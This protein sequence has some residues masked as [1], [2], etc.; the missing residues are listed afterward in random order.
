MREYVSRFWNNRFLEVLNNVRGHRDMHDLKELFI[1]L[2]FLKYANDK[3]SENEDSSIK[4]PREAQWNYLYKIISASNFLD[5]LQI[6]FSS[7]EY[8]NYQVENTFSVF[9]FNNKFKTKED[10]ELIKS[11]FYGITDFG[12]IK[13]SIDFSIIIES[14]IIDFANNEGKKGNDFTTPL[15]VSQLMIELLNPAR[16]SI[17]DSACG[18]GG[19]F[20]KVTD[21]Y[22]KGEFQFYGQEQNQSTLAL[23]KLRFAFNQDD[24]IQFSEAKSTLTEDQF[25]NL[26]VDYIVMHPPFS[27]RNWLTDQIQYDPRFEYGLPPK[28]NA[29]FAW[30]QHALFH[31]NENGKSAVLLNNSS[32]A[33]GG[34]EAEIR[35][36]IIE[37]DLIESIISLPSQLFSNTSIPASIWLLNKNKSNKGEVLFID[38]SS[39]GK[40]INRSQRLLVDKDILEISKLFNSWQEN[41]LRYSEKIGFNKSVDISEIR[42]TDYLLTPVRYV[43]IAELD[44]IDLSKAVNLGDILEYARPTRLDPDVSYKRLSIKDLASNQDS[45]FLDSSILEKGDFRLD[46]RLLEDDILLISRLGNKLKPTYHK[47]SSDKIAFSS[48]VIF[49]FKVDFKQIDIDYLIAELHK[50]YVQFQ[51]DNYRKGTGMSTI[52]RQDLLNVQIFVPPLNE[53]KE[54]FEKEREVRFQSVAKDLGFEKEIAKLKEA[55]MKDLGSK[56]HNIMQH[57]NNVK[58]STDV[59]ITMMELNNGILKSDEVI[60]PRRGVTVEKRFLRLQESLGKVIY[61]VDN[62]TNELR[63]DEA[64]IIDSV[65]FIKECKE[66]GLQNDLF[67]IEI[68]VEKAT[69]QEQNPLIS[70]SKNDFE[71]IYNN[72]LENAINHGFVNKSKSYIF[73]ISIAYIDDF[74]EINFVNNGK[75]FPKGIAENF[76]VKGEKAGLTA[77]TGIGLWKV[78]EIAKHFNCNLEVFDEPESEFP[79]GFKFQFNLETL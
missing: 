34:K 67:S 63:Y 57:L 35:K 51:L 77:G 9:D 15:S 71:E 65:K 20:Q 28:S 55:Q 44:K 21:N 38:A 30:I 8:E 41:D 74:L 48:T 46:Y 10:V 6:A 27:G 69:F 1:S 13:E 19:F 25:P 11:L 32:L 73:R 56:K 59:L 39:I 16:G 7:L 52:N 66:R 47:S 61:Y 14:L 17:L 40:M 3:F 29:N 22:P 24:S 5:F 50:D 49:S 2:I 12:F 36:N 62:I 70:I 43:G 23:A 75:P 18:T 78:A 64:E 53:Q 26:K 72:I 58:A 79:V 45:F 54:I 33:T 4:V 76:D 37:A 42:N 68:I 31:L 60:D